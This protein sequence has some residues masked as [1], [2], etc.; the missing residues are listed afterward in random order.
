MQSSQIPLSISV[1]AYRTEPALLEA[2]LVSI[3]ASPLSTRV[4]VT[5]N[6]SGSGLKE[7]AERF[8]AIYLHPGRNLGFGRG[9]N[10]ALQAVASSSKYH[11][12]LNPDVSFGPSVLP[13]IH[14]FMEA[15]PGI[16]WVMPRVLYPDG[17]QQHLCKRLP[18]PW[19]LFSRRFFAIRA[20][21]LMEKHQHRFKCQDLDLSR[22]RSVPNLSGCFAFVR[23]SLLHQV[24]GFDERFFL[25]LE[26]TD[27]V[28]RVGELAQTVFYPHVS[29]H[30]VRGRGSYQDLKLLAHH[31]RSAIQYFSKWGWLVDSKRKKINQSVAVEEQN[32]LL[33]EEALTRR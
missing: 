1:V 24:G 9:H 29:V 11:L 20:G 3:A 10:L 17:S 6:S 13:E 15:N 26:D 16:G 27:L 5:D 22:P 30:H 31:L 33:P 14:A 4:Y 23:T 7:I 25:Y 32:I 12:I 2:A 28:R 18:T 19:D 8:H 21:S